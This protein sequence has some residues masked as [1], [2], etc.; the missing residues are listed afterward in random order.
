MQSPTGH[1]RYNISLTPENVIA[2]DSILE[3]RWENRSQL[4]DQLLDIW[5]DAGGPSYVNKREW[6]LAKNQPHQP[7]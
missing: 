1:R 7:L 6:R 5:L 2:V 3:D 4:I